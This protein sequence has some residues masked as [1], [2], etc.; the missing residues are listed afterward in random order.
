MLTSAMGVLAF[1]RNRRHEDQRR[2]VWIPL[3]KAPKLRVE[4]PRP[5]E[6]EVGLLVILECLGGPRV[7]KAGR[8]NMTTARS[9][10]MALVIGLMRI[11]SSPIHRPAFRLRGQ[12]AIVT[13]LTRFYYTSTLTCHPSCRKSTPNGADFVVSSSAIP[14]LACADAGARSSALSLYSGSASCSTRLGLEILH[15][16]GV[17]WVEP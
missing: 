4:G 6:V 12:A 16:C 5:V 14:T 8:K 9:K 7:V 2:L 3:V 1:S 11:V 10:E 15:H 17:S 13:W